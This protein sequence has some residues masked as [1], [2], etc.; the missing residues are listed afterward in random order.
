MNRVPSVFKKLS[1]EL[2][3]E[4]ERSLA[5]PWNHPH[6]WTEFYSLYHKA[7]HEWRNS[8]NPD[9][10]YGDLLLLIEKWVNATNILALHLYIGFP[11]KSVVNHQ[12]AVILKT[13]S[14]AKRCDETNPHKFLHDI[15]PIK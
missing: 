15:Y 10:T 1:P 8:P 7:C 3:E 6:R 13:L 2:L 11:K 9:L 4:L 12:S 5:R 14:E